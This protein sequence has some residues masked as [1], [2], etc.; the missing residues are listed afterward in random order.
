MTLCLQGYS[1]RVKVRTAITGSILLSFALI[2]G[3]M[4]SSCISGYTQRLNASTES[5]IA[6]LLPSTQLE[7]NFVSRHFNYLSSYLSFSSFFF[8]QEMLNWNSWVKP[9]CFFGF[10]WP[11]L[12]WK[13]KSVF[14]AFRYRNMKLYVLVCRKKKRCHS[15]KQEKGHTFKSFIKL[16]T[17]QS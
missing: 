4:V 7:R 9:G 15:Q 17:L 11:M 2:S 5:G 1:V 16:L 10:P 8:K 14:H 12:L 3:Q 6:Y 13:V